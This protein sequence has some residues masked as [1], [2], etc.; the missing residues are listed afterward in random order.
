MKLSGEQVSNESMDILKMLNS[1]FNE[2]A[3]VLMQL[4]APDTASSTLKWSAD[5][6][7]VRTT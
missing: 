5:G 4:L 7:G 6:V 2:F 1:E 3:K